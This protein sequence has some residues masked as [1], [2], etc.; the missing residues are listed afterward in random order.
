MDFVHFLRLVNN[1]V[2][3]VLG[4]CGPDAFW[5]KESIEGSIVIFTR[6][7]SKLFNLGEGFNVRIVC[8]VIYPW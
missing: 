5:R 4:V 8:G 7:G 6:K 2:M 1:E 3:E